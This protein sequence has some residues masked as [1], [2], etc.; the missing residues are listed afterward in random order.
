MKE[1]KKKS[2]FKT[3]IYNHIINNLKEYII[4]TLIFIVGIIL[5]VLFINNADQTV[6]T[7]I[8]DYINQFIS[9]IKGEY[10]IDKVGLLLTSIKNN[11]LL[12]IILWFVGSTVVGLPIVAAIIGIR[13]FSI[14]YTV[15][16]SVAVLGAGK[17][18]L[19]SLSSMLMQNLLFIPAIFALAVSG[20]KL[21]KS[22]MKDKRKENIKL[23]IYRHTIFSIIMLLV[24]VV[25]SIVEVYVSSNIITLCVNYL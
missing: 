24:L 4:V 18:S 20:I 11:I 25:S 7:Q 17:G 13:G 23:E 14:G 9:A 3:I 21:Y 15:A 2:V 1:Q 16:S 22:I 8:S 6:Q 19:F 5:G 10:V 12:A